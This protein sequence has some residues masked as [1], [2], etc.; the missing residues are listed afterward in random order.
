[1]NLAY[2]R[3]IP[4]E[5]LEQWIAYSGLTKQELALIQPG[6]PPALNWTD[7]GGN[8][9]GVVRSMQMWND[10]LYV[11]G[12]FEIDGVAYSIG[13][14]EDD[15]IVPASFDT[16]GNVVDLDVYDGQLVVAGTFEGFSNFAWVAPDSFAVTYQEIGFSKGPA[17]M[18]IEVDG[19]DL[20][21]STDAS[22]IIQMHSV[23]HWNAGVWESL[24]DFD[25]NVWCLEVYDGQLVA[26]GAFTQ[27]MSGD[28]DL[29]HLAVLGDDGWMQL[30]S[31]TESELLDLEAS[32]DSLIAVGH[33]YE[34][35]DSEFK[36]SWVWDGDDLN[37]HTWNLFQYPSFSDQHA[38]RVSK[39]FGTH[40][41]IGGHFA[42]YPSTLTT[43]KSVM[44][45]WISA[46][47]D[48]TTGVGE[49]LLTP[50]S[51]G[52]YDITYVGDRLFVCGDIIGSQNLVAST[53][54][55]AYLGIEQPAPLQLNVWPNPTAHTLNAE[56]PVQG[57]GSYV[58]YATSGAEVA[59]NLISTTSQ[60]SIPVAGLA[61]GTYTLVVYVE[62]QPYTNVFVK[63]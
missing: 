60:L 40:W 9:T 20:Y 44:E 10:E 33:A 50:Q 24:G 18:C 48:E 7:H 59:R 17:S 51:G 26:G 57:Q 12:N 25:M 1:M 53:D 32:G 52:I 21:T 30:G 42:A 29:N 62:G 46:G 47:T 34:A 61:T 28:G 31:G 8:L 39:L 35:T 23:Y 55:Y 63:E 3:E 54:A 15:V 43:G 11:G 19:D 5:W 49:P 45:G 36:A 14:L 16:G 58:I 56:L 41:I 27:S 22:G 37:A 6:Y 2:I 13:I 38:M 4:S